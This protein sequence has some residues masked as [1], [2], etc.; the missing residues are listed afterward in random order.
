V[1][2]EAAREFPQLPSGALETSHL[3]T[4]F[5]GRQAE[6]IGAAEARGPPPRRRRGDET[7]VTAT[8]G[9]QTRAPIR[10][11]AARVFA[12]DRLVAGVFGTVTVSPSGP[13]TR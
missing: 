1:A 10:R 12:S 9:H 5:G 3:G 11:S 7:K 2:A 13:V 8:A 6:V 4:E